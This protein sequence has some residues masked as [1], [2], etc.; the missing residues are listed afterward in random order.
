MYTG[1][2]SFERS[3]SLSPVFTLNRSG[4]ALYAVSWIRSVHRTRYTLV[5]RGSSNRSVLRA[6]PLRSLGPVIM[7]HPVGSHVAKMSLWHFKVML[8]HR[9]L[10]LPS[11]GPELCVF[12]SPVW[13]SGRNYLGNTP[14]EWLVSLKVTDVLEIKT[15]ACCQQPNPIVHRLWVTLCWSLAKLWTYVWLVIKSID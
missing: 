9:H 5:S 2:P 8:S 13:R 10:C 7:R 3:S 4:V 6:F 14:I 11:I 15:A 12:T 1:F